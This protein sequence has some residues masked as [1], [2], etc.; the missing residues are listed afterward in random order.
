MGDLEKLLKLDAFIQETLSLNPNAPLIPKA[1]VGDYV[2]P[3]N[4]YVWVIIYH[5]KYDPITFHNL[6]SS[7]LA[8][9]RWH[10]IQTRV[11]AAKATD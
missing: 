11:S 7:A 8:L 3:A 10:H 4:C 9:Y 5:I 6:L 2:R 1:T